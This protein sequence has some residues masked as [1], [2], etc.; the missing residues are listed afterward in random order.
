ML[1]TR[2]LVRKNTCLSCDKEFNWKDTNMEIVPYAV[3]YLRDY[4]TEDEIKAKEINISA[5]FDKSDSEF[6]IS[7][8]VTTRLF[9]W[10]VAA[11]SALFGFLKI[12]RK[13]SEKY[14]RK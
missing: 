6:K 7:T 11:I 1:Q 13:E 8:S 5:D 4:Y 2:E 3:E 14:E 10:L 9:F 12:Q